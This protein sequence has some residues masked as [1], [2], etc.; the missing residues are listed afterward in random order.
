MKK[1]S[2]DFYAEQ[3]KL[4]DEIVSAIREALGKERLVLE[5]SFK[6]EA[7]NDLEAVSSEGVFFNCTNPEK[8]GDEYPL[9]ELGMSDA[10]Y[11]LSIIEN[12]GKRP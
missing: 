10:I 4:H 5:D 12:K 3:R 1:T 8:D 9:G 6:D 11:I 7:N 2:D